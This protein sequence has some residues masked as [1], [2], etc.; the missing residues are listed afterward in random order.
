MTAYAI[1]ATRLDG[2]T[3]IES[4][5]PETLGDTYGATYATEREAER[6]AD[7][8]AAERTLYDLTDAEY[9]VVSVED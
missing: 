5:T 3:R 9:R 2:S 6:V 8:L 1:R 4:S 7:Q